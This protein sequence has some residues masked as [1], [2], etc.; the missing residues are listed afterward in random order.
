MREI[1]AM[2]QFEP[3]IAPAIA[4]AMAIAFLMVRSAWRARQSMV[5]HPWE[6]GLLYIDGTF[7]RDLPPGRYLAN[8]SRL[9]RVQTTAPQTIP[10]APQEALSAD[11]FAVRLSALVTWRLP[12]EHLR[13][14]LESNATAPE[15]RIRLAATQALRLVVNAH[16]LDDLLGPRPVLDEEFAAHLR[17]SPLVQGLEIQSAETRDLILAAEV[18]RMLTEAE[19]NRREA[20]A[21]LERARGEQAV[22]RSLANSARMLKGNPALMNLRLLHALQPASGKG[23][24]TIVLGA[25]QGLVPLTQD[26]T[27][28]PPDTPE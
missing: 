5:I 13:Q 23:R 1:F 3:F 28:D 4:A 25:P 9:F 16:P 18:R 15:E 6:H 22:L 14:V 8:R 11:R 12:A 2:D 10:I 26:D 7:A 27:P 24:P 17:V 21:T 19:R 20:T